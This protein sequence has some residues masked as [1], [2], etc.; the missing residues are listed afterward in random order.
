MSDQKEY[1]VTETAVWSGLEEFL[2]SE[3]FACVGGKA[4]V[5]RNAV[6]HHHYQ[7]LAAERDSRLL[8][9]H[10]RKF[11]ERRDKISELF[12]TFIATFAYP[13]NASEIEFENLLWR[14]LQILHNIDRQYYSWAPGVPRDPLADKFAFSLASQPFFIVGMHQQASRKTR[15]SDWPTLVFNSHIQFERLRTN[16]L[17]PKIRSIVRRRELAIQGSLNPRLIDFGYRPESIRYS[18]RAVENS[19]KCPFSA[20]EGGFRASAADS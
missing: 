4:A 3:E 1:P 19:W 10:L 16:G 7:T 12:A 17:M 11:A 18:G 8:Y 15:R 13:R 5:K 2:L 9:D 20:E 6:E 14:Q